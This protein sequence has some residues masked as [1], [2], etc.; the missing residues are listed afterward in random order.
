MNEA[1]EDS[2]RVLE[3]LQLISLMTFNNSSISTWNSHHIFAKKYIL[4]FHC[5]FLKPFLV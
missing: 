3:H 4:A 1:G 2:P 5:L